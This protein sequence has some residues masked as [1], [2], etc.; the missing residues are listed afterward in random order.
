M[1][2]VA[3]V[4]N[5]SRVSEDEGWAQMDS[6]NQPAPSLESSPMTAEDWISS[7]KYP[8]VFSYFIY[9][10]TYDQADWY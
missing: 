5:S 2:L 4:F 6:E 8:C 7:D 3:T 1:W 9:K 10:H